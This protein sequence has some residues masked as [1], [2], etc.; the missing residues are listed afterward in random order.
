MIPDKSAHRPGDLAHHRKLNLS[1]IGC[2]YM[3]GSVWEWTLDWAIDQETG[4]CSG[5][6]IALGGAWWS[7]DFRDLRVAKERRKAPRGSDDAIG[8]RW[9]RRV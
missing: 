8:F 1:H 4:L 2:Q 3:A 7:D 6:K 5:E 9:V